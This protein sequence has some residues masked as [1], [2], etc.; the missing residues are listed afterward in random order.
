MNPIPRLYGKLDPGTDAPDVIRIQPMPESML[1]GHNGNHT[2]ITRF[3]AP[4]DADRCRLCPSRRP[5]R[6]ATVALTVDARAVSRSGSGL[7]VGR[8]R[9]QAIPRALPRPPAEGDHP[10][11]GAFLSRT[12]LTRD[13]PQF[14]TRACKI[15]I[16]I[17]SH[18]R[19]GDD[20][21]TDR[22]RAMKLLPGYFGRSDRS[23]QQ[24]HRF[25]RPAR[26]NAPT[27]KTR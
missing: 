1:V 27:P 7:R 15:R 12:E 13:G 10:G 14:R 26:P 19:A 22:H 21:C 25:S 3:W 23:A 6:V 5:R 18:S 24:R 20:K 17:R 9:N 16:R 4:G 11:G 2:V 8:V